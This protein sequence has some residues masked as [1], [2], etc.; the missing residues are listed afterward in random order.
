MMFAYWTFLIYTGCSDSYSV[1]LAG[2]FVPGRLEY[3]EDSCGLE[4]TISQLG[5]VYHFGTQ[6]QSMSWDSG[7]STGNMGSDMWEACYMNVGE[8]YSTWSDENF[9]S[10]YCS[11]SLLAEHVETLFAVVVEREV[12]SDN[13]DAYQSFYGYSDGMFVNKDQIALS[14]DVGFNCYESSATGSYQS[15]RTRFSVMLERVSN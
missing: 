6:P 15:C 7:L 4:P 13:E 5:L 10:F 2:S 1:D 8:D 3:L 9:P 11:E 14:E 12:C